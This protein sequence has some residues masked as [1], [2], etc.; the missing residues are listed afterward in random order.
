MKNLMSHTESK[1]EYILKKH[2]IDSEVNQYDFL[3]CLSLP[4]V[5]T[6]KYFFE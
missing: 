3:Y 1:C 6:Q 4:R 2:P 5:P